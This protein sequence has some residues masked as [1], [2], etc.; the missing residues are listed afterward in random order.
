M[1]ATNG[2]YIKKRLIWLITLTT[3]LF[4]PNFKPKREQL[5]RIIR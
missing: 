5:S 3:E 1:L 2:G 4:L